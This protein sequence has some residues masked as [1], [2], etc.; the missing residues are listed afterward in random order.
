MR[1]YI[2]IQGCRQIFLDHFLMCFFFFVLEIQTE[3]V[4]AI[5]TVGIDLKYHCTKYTFVSTRLTSQIK[6]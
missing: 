1:I 5:D 3:E 4:T 2:K 6:L